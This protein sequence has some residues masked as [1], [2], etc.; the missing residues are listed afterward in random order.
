[1]QELKIDN[2]EVADLAPLSSLTKLTKLTMTNNKVASIE[3]LAHL[4]NLSVLLASGNPI[5]STKPLA[6]L[7]H[8]TQVSVDSKSTAFDI[9]DFAKS[10]GTLTTLQ[11]SGADN[12]TPQLVHSEV[13]KQLTK[14]TTLQVSSTSLT[15]NDLNSIGAMTQLTSLQADRSNISDMSFAG[16][17]TKLTKLD[18]SNQRVRMS[19]NTTPFASPLK[20]VSGTA[21]AI[22]NSAD[23]ANDG[24]GRVKIVSPIYDNNTHE[25][26]AT[27]AKNVTV[28]TATAQFNGQLT[29]SAT[30]PKAE[31]RDRKSVV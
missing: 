24:A 11:L 2:N 15:D 1:M 19:T 30:L 23:L 10:A 5:A 26:S 31:Q 7:T 27:W 3:P 16:R 22:T 6:N 4:A 8:L 12:G 29:V 18:V 9:S 13:L 20:G 14:V 21:V 17:L 28:G 25:L